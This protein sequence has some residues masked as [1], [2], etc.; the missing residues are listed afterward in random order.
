[1]AEEKTIGLSRDYIIHPGET[2]MEVM[3]DKGMNQK[4]L[5][6]RC[7]VS[8]KHISTVLNGKKNISA[9]FA[10]KLEYALGIEAIFWMNLQSNYDEE[11]IKFEDIHGITSEEIDVL[12]DLKEVL[13]DYRKKGFICENLSNVDEVL[14]LRRLFNLS[15][16]LNIPK[17]THIGA[18][19]LKKENVNVNCYTMF[20]W[21]KYCELIDKDVKI[22]NELNIPLLKKSIPEIKSI[23]FHNSKSLIGDLKNALAK[24]GIKFYLVPNYKGAPVQ[25]YIRHNNDSGVSLFMTIRGSFADIFWFSLFHEIAHILNGDAKNSFIDYDEMPEELENKADEVASNI[26]ISSSSYQSF[27]EKNDFTIDAIRRLANENNVQIFMCLG[28]LMRDKYVDYTR[29]SNYRLRYQ[30]A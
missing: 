4:E 30:L 3:D 26:L 12:K 19:R 15:N 28:R 22:E 10:K 1:M 27:V 29:Y 20:A 25:G 11:I 23:M 21:E 2:L 17:L 24:C 9:D 7:G 8:E 18:F 13:V 16:L 6:I 5:A 14:Q